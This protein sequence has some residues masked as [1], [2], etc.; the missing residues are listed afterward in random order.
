MK[1]KKR[2]IFHHVFKPKSVS[3]TKQT[4]R[5]IYNFPS[6][7]IYSN[8]SKK[9]FNFLFSERYGK[10]TMYISTTGKNIRVAV[11]NNCSLWNCLHVTR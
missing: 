11:D 1:Y 6:R 8:I 3:G 4:D 9:V 10:S 5:H 7:R 2:E